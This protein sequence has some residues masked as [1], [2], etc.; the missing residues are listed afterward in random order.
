MSFFIYAAIKS[1]QAN[2]IVRRSVDLASKPGTSSVFTFLAELERGS[3]T[4]VQ[5]HLSC[6]VPG[7]LALGAHMGTRMHSYYAS[8]DVA[9]TRRSCSLL[10]RP[11]HTC[12]WRKNSSARV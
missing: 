11:R 1:M 3:V 4:M 12:V 10:C 6:F 7:L 5:E 8:G 9:Y 2:M